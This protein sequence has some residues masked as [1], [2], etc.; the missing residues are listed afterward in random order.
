VGREDGCVFLGFFREVSVPLAS[1]GEP[2]RLRATTVA[3]TFLSGSVCFGRPEGVLVPLVD[4][5]DSF[6][7]SFRALSSSAF[8]SSSFR[9]SVS[10]S[11]ELCKVG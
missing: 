8:L 4:V 11:S 3:V 10:V 1:E 9:R 6:P 5:S 7:F 2:A